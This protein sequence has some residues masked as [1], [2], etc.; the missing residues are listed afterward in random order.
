MYINFCKHDKELDIYHNKKKNKAF[1]ERKKKQKQ[2]TKM[3][4]LSTLLYFEKVVRFF[5]YSYF[6]VGSVNRLI[7]IWSFETECKIFL[8]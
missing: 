3:P 4:H 6:M 2:R 5:F 1:L 8:S 7:N